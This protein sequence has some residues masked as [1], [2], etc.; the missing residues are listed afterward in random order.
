MRRRVCC[1]AVLRS[2]RCCWGCGGYTGKSQC[3]VFERRSPK[4][5]SEIGRPLVRL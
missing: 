4:K 1:Q 5:L 3:K 2:L